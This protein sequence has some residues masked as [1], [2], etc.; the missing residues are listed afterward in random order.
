MVIF[1][2]RQSTAPC[3]RYSYA[4]L[5]VDHA[6]RVRLAQALLGLAVTECRYSMGMMLMVNFMSLP[7]VRLLTLHPH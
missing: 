6:G 4:L 1:A 2:S 3:Q 5:Y 7:V